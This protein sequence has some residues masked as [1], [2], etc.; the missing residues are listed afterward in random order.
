MWIAFA[1]AIA[2]ACIVMVLNVTFARPRAM[3]GAHPHAIRAIGALAAGLAILSGFALVLGRAALSPRQATDW[4]GWCIALLSVFVMLEGVLARR[5]TFRVQLRAIV[6]ATLIVFLLL[7]P[8]RN[9][10]PWYVSVTCVASLTAAI[11]IAWQSYEYVAQSERPGFV[12]ALL[13]LTLVGASA[14]ML[15][16]GSAKL[17]QL[18]GVAASAAAGMTVLL[19]KNPA[20]YSFSGLVSVIWP[21]ASLVGVLGSIYASPPKISMVLILL[22]CGA[23]GLLRLPRLKGRPASQQFGL[24]AC[25]SAMLL[26]LAIL[27]AYRDYAVGPQYEV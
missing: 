19:L 20:R 6:V 1:A 10:F 18:V 24:A 16:G 21:A 7:P 8:I 5:E 17:G 9:V 22:S 26:A 25:V 23:I 14:V 12:A 2:P 4:I 15:F 27:L 11:V 13:T 3:A